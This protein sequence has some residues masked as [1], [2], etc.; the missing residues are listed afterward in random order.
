MTRIRDAT[1]DL[2]R[3]VVEPEVGR[4]T[5]HLA[6]AHDVDAIS[7]QPREQQRP[8]IDLADVPQAG[9]EQPV[10]HARSDISQAPSPC[11]VGHIDVVRK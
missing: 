7:R 6:T 5:H 3:R 11:G 8:R 4:G 10:T 2:D 1:Q 9:D